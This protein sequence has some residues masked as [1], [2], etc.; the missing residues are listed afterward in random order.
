MLKIKRKLLPNSWETYVTHWLEYL[1]A[2]GYTED[3][4]RC[5]YY[6]ISR[7]A[8]LLNQPPEDI[9]GQQ[10]VEL[11]AHQDWK[12]ETRK[13]YSSTIRSFYSYMIEEEIIDVNPTVKLPKIRKEYAIPHPCPDYIIRGALA[14]VRGNKE[15]EAMLRLGAE[16]GLRR[17]EIAQV[18]SSD[19]MM[20]NTHPQLLVHGKGRKERTVPIAPDLAQIIAN[21]HGYMFPGRWTGHVEAFYI[22]HHISQLLGN[23]YSTHSLRHRYATKAYEST[24]DLLLVSKLLGHASVETTQIYISLTFPDSSAI[25]EAVRL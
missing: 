25:T 7:L 1:E 16:C 10:L 21:K 5:R 4:I 14:R 13:G 24:H 18:S 2:S 11:F 3:T 22:A 19:I 8:R 12:R 15:Y 20:L 23:G 17:S 6:K 9:T